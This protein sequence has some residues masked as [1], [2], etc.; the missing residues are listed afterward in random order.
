VVDVAFK[1][2]PSVEI[3]DL[4]GLRGLGRTVTDLDK[5]KFKLTPTDILGLVGTSATVWFVLRE[6]PKE[7]NKFFKGLGIFIMLAGIAGVALSLRHTLQEPKTI[8]KLVSEK[9]AEIV[10]PGAPNG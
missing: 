3:N 5:I 9:K 10:S 8:A 6:L 4:F 1:T 7:K 2:E